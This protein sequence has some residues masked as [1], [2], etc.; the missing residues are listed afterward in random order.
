MLPRQGADVRGVD[1][2]GEMSSLCAPAP[3][4]TRYPVRWCDRC[5]RR[6]RWRLMSYEWYEPLWVCLT[7]EKRRKR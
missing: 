3:I 5:K 2:A 6:R 1:G 7:C 4:E